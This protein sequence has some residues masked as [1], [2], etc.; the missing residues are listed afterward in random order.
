[1][2]S[3]LKP[4]MYFVRVYEGSCNFEY[5]YAGFEQAE[6]HLKWELE[7]GHCASLFAHY[8]DG[9]VGWDECIR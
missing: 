3:K 6:S 9:R 4:T 8:F 7:S 5:E 1:M 2:E